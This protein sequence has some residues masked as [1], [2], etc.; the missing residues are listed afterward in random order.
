MDRHKVVLSYRY[1]HSGTL[2]LT[3]LEKAEIENVVKYF[4][5]HRDG[6]HY[7]VAFDGVYR[8]VDYNTM[9]NW[10]EKEVGKEQVEEALHESYTMEGFYTY[11]AVDVLNDA[12]YNL[13][14]IVD[15]LMR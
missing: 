14:E 11:A 6:N 13:D 4:I 7:L 3:D 9:F 1:V 8:C 2:L 12:G 15:I 10:F 5:K